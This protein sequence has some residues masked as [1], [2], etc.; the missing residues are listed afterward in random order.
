MVVRQRFRG[1]FQKYLVVLFMAVAIPLAING[2]IEAWLGYRDQRAR[3]DQLLSVQATSAAARIDGFIEGI[4]NELGWLVQLPW[5]DEPDEQRR[6]DALRL[7][8]QAPAIVSLQLVDH[9]G[10]ERLYVSRIGLN[11][12]DSRADRSGDPAVAGVRSARLWFGDVRYN[13]G[14]EP[15][16]TLAISGNRPS[17]GA[18]IAEVNLK[19]VWDVISAIKVGKTG[20]AFVLDRPGRLIA[21]PD[22][23]LVLRGADEATSKPFQAIRNAIGRPGV[24]FATG[25]NAQ[26]HEVAAA[27]ATISGLDWTVVVEQPLAEAFGPIYAALWRTAELVLVGTIF[28][29]VLAY[30]LARRMT[31]PIRLLEEGTE[32]IGAGHFDHRIGIQTGDELQFLADSFNRMA[33]ELA[34]SREQQERIAKLRRFLAPQVADLID[35]AGDDSV[36]EGRRTEVVVVFCDL[37]GFTSFSAGVAPEEVMSVLSE[38]YETL[39]RTITTFAATLISFSGDGLM[40]LVNAPVPVEEPAL[41]AFDLAMEMQRSVQELIARW[42]SQGYQIG[43]GVGLA[44]GSATVG[45]IGY[46][47]RFDYTA[48]GSVVNLA[49]RLCASAADREILIDARVAEAVKDRRPLKG[50]GNRPLKGYIET[51]PVFGASL[52]TSRKG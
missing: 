11:R 16:L 40:V 36:L 17:V 14:S 52:D 10:Q 28:S 25:R 38:Y 33:A 7:F 35:Q 48:I 39:G 43:F 34:V 18:V 6:T 44:S 26:G 13:R 27:S 41:R 32:R 46:E 22:I 37:R 49:A 45:R 5:T 30:A 24:G 1:L 47:S 20:F 50:L 51:M 23:S 42:R 12:I 21:H 31:D 19:L 15:Y 4:E 8:R 3:L 2:V 29:G 9:K